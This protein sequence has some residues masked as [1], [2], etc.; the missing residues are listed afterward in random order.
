MTDSLDKNS[1]VIAGLLN[2]LA[3]VS[4]E[5]AEL[6]AYRREAD[7]FDPSLSTAG[8]VLDLLAIEPDRAERE[9]LRGFIKRLQEH[10]QAKGDSVA[11]GQ[12]LEGLSRS[13][14]MGS[15]P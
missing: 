11:A 5:K 10:F 1:E 8:I 4:A 3:D 15:G 13:G 14:E 2:R 6:A 7:L 12:I 9:V